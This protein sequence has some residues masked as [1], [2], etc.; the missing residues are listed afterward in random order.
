MTTPFYTYYYDSIELYF[1][2][3]SNTPWPRH[4]F[5]VQLYIHRFKVISQRTNYTSLPDSNLDIM[6]N[7]RKV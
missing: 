4:V 5:S 1:G 7:L 6:F 3:V 2:L